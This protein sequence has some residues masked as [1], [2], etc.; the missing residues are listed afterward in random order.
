MSERRNAN[1]IAKSADND[2][3]NENLSDIEE[4]SVYHMLHIQPRK[5]LFVKL[6]LMARELNFEINTGSGLFII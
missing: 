6:R 2:Y 5:P 3:V 4:E 1:D